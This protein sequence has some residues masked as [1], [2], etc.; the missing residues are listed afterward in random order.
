MIIQTVTFIVKKKARNI[1]K[2]R[3]KE[4]SLRCDHL[5]NA[6]LVNAGSIRQKILMNLC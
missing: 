6:F 2:K 1:L 5:T 4:M 3:R